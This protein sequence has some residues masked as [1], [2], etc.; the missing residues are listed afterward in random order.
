MGEGWGEGFKINYL[1]PLP[2]TLSGGLISTSSSYEKDGFKSN[3]S[4]LADLKQGWA[5]REGLVEALAA[6]FNNVPL[7]AKAIPSAMI[8]ELPKIQGQVGG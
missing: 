2:S 7:S 8:V 4:K 5:G 3:S 1:S 6:T